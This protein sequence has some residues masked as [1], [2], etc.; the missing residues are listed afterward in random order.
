[1]KE[2]KCDPEQFKGRIIFMSMFNDIVR[3]EKGNEETCKTN[4]HEV[5]NYARRFPRDH[6]SFLG[7]GSEKKWYGT[8]SDKF[9]GIWD[10]TAEKMMI[11][12]SETAIRFSVLP[13]ALERGELRSKR[14][15]K[16]TAHFNG[17]EQNVELILRT[18]H[19]CES[20]E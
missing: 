18:G 13:A 1:M 5:A 20:V 6:W 3:E 11:E 2:Q 4:A 14:R 19:V 9:N 7:P 8:Y 15:G 16:K 17:S 10:K 12:F